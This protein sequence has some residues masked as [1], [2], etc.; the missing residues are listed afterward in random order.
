MIFGNVTVKPI[1]EVEF[2]FLTVL[3]KKYANVVNK[4]EKVLK[5]KQ[6]KNPIIRLS[7]K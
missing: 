6:I 5:S 3:G 1:T 2:V 7:F 4:T